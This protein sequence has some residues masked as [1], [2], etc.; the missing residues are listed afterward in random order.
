MLHSCTNIAMEAC[1]FDC[2]SRVGACLKQ[3][4]KYSATSLVNRSHQEAHGRGGPVFPLYILGNKRQKL[5]P[6]LLLAQTNERLSTPKS[7]VVADDIHSCQ[8][9]KR[10][11]QQLKFTR[12]RVS[13]ESVPRG[14]GY[15]YTSSNSCCPTMIQVISMHHSG[16]CK[17]VI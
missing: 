15:M 5:A 1:E 12:V 4:C 2:T 13:T 10:I 7:A 16:V 3:V 17:V 8:C 6:P 14:S 11:L 9:R